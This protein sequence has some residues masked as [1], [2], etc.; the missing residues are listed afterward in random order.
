MPV[1]EPDAA[2]KV[3]QDHRVVLGNR[4]QFGEVRP[5]RSDNLRGMVAR[6]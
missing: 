3:E 1:V 4:E 5:N 2:P 6:E